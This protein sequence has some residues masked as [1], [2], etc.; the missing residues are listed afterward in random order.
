MFFDHLGMHGR[1]VVGCAGRRILGR[2]VTG[3]AHALVS[4]FRSRMAA[5]LHALDPFRPHDFRARFDRLCLLPLQMSHEFPFDGLARYRS[6]FEFLHDVLAHSPRDVGVIV[7]EHPAATPVLKRRGREANLDYLCNAFPNM[8][9]LDEFRSYCTSSQFLVPRVDGVWSVSSSVGY[10]ALLFGRVL[11][12]PSTT[13]LSSVADA[14][15]FGDFFNEL[16]GRKSRDVDGFLSWQLERYLVPAV[17]YNDG[18]W[19]CDYLRR[20]LDAAR[21]A[22]NPVDAF[23]PIADADTLMQAWVT[24][25]PKP[26]LR[27][28]AWPVDDAEL[29]EACRH[30]DALVRDLDAL[31]RSTSWRLTAPLR[32]VVNGVAALRRRTADRIAASIPALKAI[33]GF[34]AREL[35]VCGKLLRLALSHLTPARPAQSSARRR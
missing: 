33:G 7:T 11:G 4:A 23:V 25:A 31:L 12:T 19:L 17:L 2:P 30:R 14:T 32:A 15:T 20:R 10:Q 28:Y 18:R 13:H 5:A 3:D 6:Q 22:A 35:R 34:F 21:S 24:K 16:G 1:S 29:F 26:E 8:I 27:G 9:F